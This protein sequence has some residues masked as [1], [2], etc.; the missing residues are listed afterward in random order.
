MSSAPDDPEAGAPSRPRSPLVPRHDPAAGLIPGGTG[1]ERRD[2]DTA[3]LA[4]NLRS[5]LGLPHRDPAP[6]EAAAM[7][8]H[9][10]PSVMRGLDAGGWIAW[11]LA[12]LPLFSGP[13]PPLSVLG[14]HAERVPIA[15]AMLRADG[16]IHA[17]ARVLRVPRRDLRA[18][19]GDMGLWPWPR[20]RGG[21][22][23]QGG[24]A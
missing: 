21:S 5:V 19:L 15:L 2:V 20:V 16:N 18:T 12:G 6:G 23:G 14:P 4:A 11:S 10:I 17:A 22:D 3:D 7:C 8:A 9:T 24:P 13:L 1:I